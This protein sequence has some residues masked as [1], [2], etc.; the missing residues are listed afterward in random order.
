MAPPLLLGFL[1]YRQDW[2]VDS[3]PETRDGWSD[4]VVVKDD[5]SF[6]IIIE[7]CYADSENLDKAALGAL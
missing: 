1:S 2:N 3:N 4:I 6:G 7:V 5:N